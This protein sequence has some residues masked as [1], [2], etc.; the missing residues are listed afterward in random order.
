M[1]LFSSCGQVVN[2]R[3]VYDKET[4]QPKG[5]GFLE[6]TDTDSA[7]SA[8]R[9]L[10]EHELN[11]RTLRVDYSNDNRSTGNSNNQN[12]DSNRA[13]PQAHFGAQANG[14]RPDPSAVPPLPQ[15]VDLPPGINTYDAISRTINA[16][17]TPQLIDFISQVKGLC[18]ANPAQAQAL[19]TQAPQLAYAIFQT[20]LMMDLVD[21]TIVQQLVATA[22]PPVPPPQPQAPPTQAYQNMMPQG[23][24]PPM[25]PHPQGYPPGWGPQ[26]GHA[27]TPPQQQQYQPPPQQQAPPQAPQGITS[28]IDETTYKQLVALTAEQVA[29]LDEAT[30]GQ[31][32]ALRGALGLPYI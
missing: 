19:L 16:V 30:K 12:Q 20:M 18:S 15:G 4:G 32:R 1:D 10:N 21:P 26:A 29:T 27:P 22:P 9:N 14:G 28:Q 2:F 31:I 25:P 23:Y 3:L 7:A 8:V 5:F 6:Y 11:G 24:P 17:P 13:P